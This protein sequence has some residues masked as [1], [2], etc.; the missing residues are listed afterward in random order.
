M[1]DMLDG[2]NE[3]YNDFYGPSDDSLT[4][5]QR[6][7]RRVR[8][9]VRQISNEGKA[10]LNIE[11]EVETMEEAERKPVAVSKIITISGLPTQEVVIIPHRY[12]QIAHSLTKIHNTRSLL[13]CT[14]ICIKMHIM[15]IKQIVVLFLKYR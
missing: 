2:F 6:R 11:T 10:V 1:A 8:D 5:I 15:G 13:H 9:K 7:E 4:S 3:M 12:R 14:L